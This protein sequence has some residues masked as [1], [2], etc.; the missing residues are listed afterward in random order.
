[1]SEL[2]TLASQLYEFQGQ[3]FSDPVV[4]QR[5]KKAFARI[6]EEMYNKYGTYFLNKP[7]NTAILVGCD[8]DLVDNHPIMI[9]KEL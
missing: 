7:Y 8:F 3:D 5:F 6:L 9:Y 1:M 4:K 2:K